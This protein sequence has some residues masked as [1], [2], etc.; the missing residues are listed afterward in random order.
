MSN[1]PKMPDF[2]SFTTKHHVL[3]KEL[4]THVFIGGVI[5]PGEIPIPPPTSQKLSAIW[6]TGATCTVISPRV[7]EICALKPTGMVEVHHADGS[8]NK[9]TYL[10]SVYLPNS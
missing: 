8:A 6:D 2:L 5:P 1:N 4:A 3:A 10:L 9:Y 7:V